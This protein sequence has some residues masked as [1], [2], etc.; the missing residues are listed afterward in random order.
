[1]N[2]RPVAQET[3]LADRIDD[4]LLHVA[5][6][7]PFGEPVETGRAHKRVWRLGDRELDLDMRVLTGQIGWERAERR[8]GGRFD[9][10]KMSWI[11]VLEET[12]AIAHAPFLFDGETT[13]LAVLGHPSFDPNTIA[14]VFTTL[15]NRGEQRRG[16]NV[17]W[18][19]EP[20]L[21][22]GSFR[23]WLS[24]TDVVERVAFVAKLPNPDM[25]PEF[26]PLIDRLEAR[27]AAA[28]R[29]IWEARDEEE[30]LQDIEAD[31]DARQMIALAERGYGNVSARGHRRDGGR[32]HFNQRRLAR[33]RP[34]P[35]LP[36][37][38]GEMIGV[39]IDFALS[40]LRS[41]EADDEAT[42]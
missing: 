9:A 17:E 39:F 24:Q 18:E 23:E 15:L 26:Q 5:E 20:L 35:P 4:P 12:A 36:S 30:G 22:V 33:R 37:S 28:L 34:T 6:V 8:E 10:E 31:P 2:R 13:G 1:V 3:F 27:R 14:F 42:T 19:V 38:V 29:E 25:L 7:L 11:D 41:G 16:V 21:D 32:R 40:R